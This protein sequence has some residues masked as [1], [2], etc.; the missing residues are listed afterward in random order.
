VQ[1]VV[2]RADLDQLHRV[3]G[4]SVAQSGQSEHRFRGKVNAGSDPK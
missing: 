3:L 2:P 4:D 1:F